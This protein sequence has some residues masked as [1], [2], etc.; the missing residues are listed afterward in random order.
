MV[1]ARMWRAISLGRRG[2]K[3]FYDCLG[4]DGDEIGVG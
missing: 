4:A 1:E 3:E 2:G